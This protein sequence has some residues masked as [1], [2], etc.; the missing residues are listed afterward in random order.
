MCV[1]RLAFGLRYA[2]S[3]L[4]ILFFRLTGREFN[5]LRASTS[6][7]MSAQISSQVAWSVIKNRSRFL[8]KQKTAAF[9]SEP[10]NLT[11]ENRYYFN[12]LVRKDA[13]GLAAEK[14]GKKGA[15]VLSVRRHLLRKPATDVQTY[16]LRRDFRRQAS[17]LRSIVKTV[18]P[19]LTRAALARLTKLNRSLKPVR[20]V[21][22]RIPKFR[23]GKRF[24]KR[25]QQHHV[26]KKET[27]KAE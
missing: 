19:A 13:V 21:K 2:I 22:K 23:K 3:R 4:S 27:P 11:N 7:R 12:G 24:H 17:A 1:L 18:R 10:G 15:V 25:G 26:A 9:S 20:V 8:N 16:P 5:P 14:G 6:F